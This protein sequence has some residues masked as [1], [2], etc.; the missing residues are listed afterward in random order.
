M[1]HIQVDIMADASEIVH[2]D[3]P[4][5]P[6]YI[7]KGL[8]SYYPGK[9]AVCHWHDDLEIIL[10]LSGEMNDYINGETLLLQKGDALLINSRAMHYGYSHQ[11]HDCEFIC[12]L[13]HPSLLSANRNL[14]ENHISPFL[15]SSNITHLKLNSDDHDLTI[16]QIHHIYEKKQEQDFFYE[17]D[18]IG[19]I[20]SLTASIL[21]ISKDDHIT[22]VQSPSNDIIMLRRMVSYIQENYNTSISLDDIAA[23][24][25]ICKS[26]CCSL[27]Q[28]E[29]QMTPFGFLNDYRLKRSVE[30]LKT[31]ELPITTI[32]INCGF[33]NS[34]YFSK[35]FFRTYQC[36][37]REYR[38]SVV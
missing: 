15:F 21:R 18:I 17:L 34:S 8:L 14:F 13:F 36:T 16:K 27:F 6:L 4:D 32:A 38:K 9:R 7:K 22:D 20:Y 33:N 12:I 10:I 19:L 26:K 35:L 3:S 25:N 2:Y 5:I 11:N 37:P 29:I 30:M 28:K 1:E 24:A 31:T 23:S